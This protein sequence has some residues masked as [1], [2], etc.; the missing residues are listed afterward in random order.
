MPLTQM[1]Q[2]PRSQSVVC[3]WSPCR[4]LR[5][6]LRLPAPS[7]RCRPSCQCQQ[8]NSNWNFPARAAA[9]T[10]AAAAATAEVAAVAATT[11]V[12]AAAARDVH[13]A[14]RCT[15]HFTL[16]GFKFQISNFTFRRHRRRRCDRCHRDRRRLAPPLLLTLPLPLPPALPPPLLLLP[17]LPPETKF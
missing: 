11:L 4:L 1:V 13:G 3:R 2:P 14:V 8:L 9:A 5:C 12:A 6:A 17:W 16:L 10:T 15:V 7:C